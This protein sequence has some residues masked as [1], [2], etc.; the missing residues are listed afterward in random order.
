L[1]LDADITFPCV[2]CAPALFRESFAPRRAK[3]TYDDARKQN[4]FVRR[5]ERGF[6]RH[7]EPERSE[8][9]AIQRP[10]EALDCFVAEPVIGPGTSGNSA[11]R[12]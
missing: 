4:A 9:E 8:G 6:L 2:I 3:V 7:C 10:L 5:G 1:R 11:F 12:A